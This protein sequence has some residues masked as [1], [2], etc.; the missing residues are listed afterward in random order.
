LAPV[1]GHDGGQA[2]LLTVS[3]D[4]SSRQLVLCGELDRFG[5]SSLTE[6]SATLVTDNPGDTTVDLAAVSFIDAGGLGRLVGLRNELAAHSA[7]MKV[8]NATPRLR[9]TFTIAGL[10]VMLRPQTSAG[11]VANSY[12]PDRHDGFR[13]STT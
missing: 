7:A 9:K 5:G 11:A 4:L 3:L 10:Q 6:T 13:A 1:A 8:I 12:L 2:A